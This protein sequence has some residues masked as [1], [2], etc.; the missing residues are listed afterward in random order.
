MKQN[1]SYLTGATLPV[2][3]ASPEED[4]MKYT[5]DR[6]EETFALL[7]KEDRSMLQVPIEDLPPNAKEGSVLI[8]ENGKWTLSEAKTEETESRIRSKMDLLWK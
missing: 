5:L 7:E 4:T 3:A 2:E 8:F 6:F 1:S